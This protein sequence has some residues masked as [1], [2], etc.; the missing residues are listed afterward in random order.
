MLQC[1]QHIYLTTVCIYYLSFVHARNY[2]HVRDALHHGIVVVGPSLRS[3][4]YKRG[5]VRIAGL[6]NSKMVSIENDNRAVIEA[7]F[8]E[9]IKQSLDRRI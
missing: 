4:S 6:G 2:D 8:F 5:Q 1:W 7:G 3:L 9:I